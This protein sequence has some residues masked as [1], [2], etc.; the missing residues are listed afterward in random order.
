MANSSNPLQYIQ[1]IGRVIRRFPEK[2]EAFIYD[3]IVIPRPKS[4]P[5]DLQKYEKQIFEKELLRY[6]E[7]SQNAN[8]SVE[9]LT[10]LD[11]VYFSMR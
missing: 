10:Y 2:Q 5:E 3:M 7:I 8:N 6:Q 4:L 1:R 11:K 9:A